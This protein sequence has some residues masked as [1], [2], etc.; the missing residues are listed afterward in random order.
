[1]TLKVPITARALIQR[2]NRHIAHDG[3]LLKANRGNLHDGFGSFYLVNQTG[4]LEK[5]V[6]LE[7]FAIKIGVIKTW[8]TLR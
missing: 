7:R 5:H 3:Q 4:V 1:M 6:D 2:V 8:E